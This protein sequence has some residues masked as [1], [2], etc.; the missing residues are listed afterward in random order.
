MKCPLNA[1]AGCVVSED[2]LEQLL[3]TLVTQTLDETYRGMLQNI[4]PMMK[5]Y[6]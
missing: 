1:L 3:Q 6:A 2:L 4:S 5:S